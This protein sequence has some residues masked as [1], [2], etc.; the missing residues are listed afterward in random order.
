MKS[1]KF[2]PILLILAIF[3]CPL[4]GHSQTRPIVPRGAG[5]GRIGKP[6][7]PWGSGYFSNSLTL[8]QETISE[9]G[10][11]S[12]IMSSTN[13]SQFSVGETKEIDGIVGSIYDDTIKQEETI[14]FGNGNFTNRESEDWK[15]NASTLEVSSDGLTGTLDGALNEKCVSD[16]IWL[17]LSNATTNIA[18]WATN[19]NAEKT[20]VHWNPEKQELDAY[21]SWTIEKVSPLKRVK[22]IG[23]LYGNQSGISAATST[24]PTWMDIRGVSKAIYGIATADGVIVYEAV[25][26]E[27]IYKSVD[28]GATWTATGVS[29]AIYGIATADG[30]IVYA[31]VGQSSAGRVWK[32]IDGGNTWYILNS[33]A[34][35]YGIVTADGITVY[36]YIYI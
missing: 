36:I 1:F 14:Y 4:S 18:I 11:P 30:V 12:T 5:E 3:I 10:S 31:T 34:N 22:H 15:G 21:S 23:L 27:A 20:E 7:K 19:V 32:S 33:P 6:E 17:Y 35:L 24:N 13:I 16:G 9:W 25:A 28:G 26:N 2:L 8:G 29:K